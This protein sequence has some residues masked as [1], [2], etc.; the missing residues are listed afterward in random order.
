[1][2]FSEER[3][4]PGGC[5]AGLWPAAETAAFLGLTMHVRIRALKGTTKP[6]PHL[7]RIAG[8]PDLLSD[9]M[10]PHASR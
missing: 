8:R 9:I 2:Y 6:S 5:S 10:R 1:L 4:R 7:E 3:R